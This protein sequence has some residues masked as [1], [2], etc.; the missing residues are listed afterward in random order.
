MKVWLSIAIIGR[1]LATKL[2]RSWRKLTW[3][4]A[5]CWDCFHDWSRW[6]LQQHE[7]YAM[8]SQWLVVCVCPVLQQRSVVG[9]T[10]GIA[11]ARTSRETWFTIDWY[12]LCWP[13]QDTPAVWWGTWRLWNHC[14]VNWH[15]SIH[16]LCLL[17]CIS[18]ELWHDNCEDRQP[19]S[20]TCASACY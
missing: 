2:W 14:L 15:V 1:Q 3:Q 16:S 10:R 11:G 7:Q 20:V 4:F 13:Q 9:E 12:Q 5:E 6:W 19:M 8:S 17:I 18:L